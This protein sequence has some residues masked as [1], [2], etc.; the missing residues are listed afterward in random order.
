M[1]ALRA[2]SLVA[3]VPAD[4]R[5]AGTPAPGTL[6]RYAGTYKDSDGDNWIVR[7]K[8]DHLEVEA[9]PSKSD[10]FASASCNDC[11]FYRDHVR[12]LRFEKGPGGQ[13]MALLIDEHIGPIERAVRVEPSP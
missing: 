3:G 8:E 13:G 12:D 4:A 5:R 10:V 7:R 2:A 1:L 6:E 9:G 11:F